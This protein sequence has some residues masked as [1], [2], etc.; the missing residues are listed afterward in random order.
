MDS[1]GLRKTR[2]PLLAGGATAGRQHGCPFDTWCFRG[3]GRASDRAGVQDGER[4]FLQWRQ[5][6]EIPEP[7]RSDGPD[8]IGGSPDGA[9]I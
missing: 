9:D 6:V 5:G 7:A 8:R 2:R 1:A 3:P 4:A